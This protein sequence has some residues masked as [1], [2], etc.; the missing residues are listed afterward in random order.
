ME[1]SVTP[2]TE[3]MDQKAIKIIIFGNIKQFFIKTKIPLLVHQ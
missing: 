2:S 1:D 3:N